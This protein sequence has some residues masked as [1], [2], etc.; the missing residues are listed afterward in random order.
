MECVACHAHHIKIDVGKYELL[1][2]AISV[3]SNKSD[4][5][6]E[7]QGYSHRELYSYVKDYPTDVICA[8]KYGQE[9]R[10]CF[11]RVYCKKLYY[12]CQRQDQN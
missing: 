4:K 8:G 9:T 2:S 3:T 6:N 10:L 1:D 5:I 11:E 7:N 12:H